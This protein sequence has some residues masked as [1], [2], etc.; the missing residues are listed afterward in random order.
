MK[1][2]KWKSIIEEFHPFFNFDLMENIR[3]GRFQAKLG[4]K[5]FSKMEEN[6]VSPVFNANETLRPLSATEL[7]AHIP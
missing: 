7:P 3:N 6:D 5:S 1:W 4:S 2:R